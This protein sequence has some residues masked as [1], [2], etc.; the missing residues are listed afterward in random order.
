MIVAE[1]AILT[2]T[3]ALLPRHLVFGRTLK[4]FERAV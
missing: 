2:Q 3:V 4:C 1:K